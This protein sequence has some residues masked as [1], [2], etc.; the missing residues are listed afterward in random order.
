MQNKKKNILSLSLIVALLTVIVGGTYA[1]FTA[2][3]EDVTNR[4]TMGDVSFDE[5]E[6][7]GEIGKGLNES[8]V[9]KYGQKIEVNKDGHLVDKDGNYVTDKGLPSAEPV[10]ANKN[11]LRVK[12]N[13]YT[14]VPG[15]EYTKDPTLYIKKGSEPAWVY[16]EVINGLKD[17]E[18]E[19]TISDQMT[20]DHGW[21]HIKGNVWR[22]EN[23]VDARDD[24]EIVTVFE[25]FTIKSDIK[26]GNNEYSDIKIKGFAIQA[27]QVNKETADA[28][29]LKVL[30]P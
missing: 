30:T 27:D 17:V 6:G 3:T 26:N 11:S 1:Y 15:R 28:E 12:E 20:E 13:K 8:L 19:K 7:Y 29:A 21:T 22:Q 23:P 4:F 18:A 14:L 16:V 9:D 2:E 5:T 25:K 24:R 10:E